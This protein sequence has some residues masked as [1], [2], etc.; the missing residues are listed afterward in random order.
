MA[1]IG[2]KLL[3]ASRLIRPSPSLASI[4]G[5]QASR[6]TCRCAIHTTAITAQL[7]EGATHDKIQLTTLTEDTELDWKDPRKKENR[8]EKKSNID[9]TIRHFTVNFVRSPRDVVLLSINPSNNRSL[10][11][12]TSCCPWCASSH[13]G[14]RWR[15]GRTS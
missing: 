8:P 1:S 10:G 2:S 5:G 15:S 11:S 9:T 3:R 6:L 14:T 4:R 13:S 12:S 7:T